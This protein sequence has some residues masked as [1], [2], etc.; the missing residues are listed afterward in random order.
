MNKRILIVDDEPLTRRSLYEILKFDGYEVITADDGLAALEIIKKAPPQIA[1]VDLK[2]PRLDGLGLLKEIKANSIKTEVILITGYGSI[3]TAVEAMKQGA[4]DYISKP[5][6]DSEIKINTAIS[7]IDLNFIKFIKFVRFIKFI[8][9][10]TLFIILNSL[11]IY[12]YR[13]QIGSGMTKAHFN[14]KCLL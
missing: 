11:L 9:L 2:M 6:V 13:F 14:P 12:F 4:F 7:L 3:E 10:L 8:K 5:I 1:I